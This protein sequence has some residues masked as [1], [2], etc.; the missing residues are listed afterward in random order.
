MQLKYTLSFLLKLCIKKWWQQQQKKHMVLHVTNIF[1]SLDCFCQGNSFEKPCR[2]ARA[3]Q[4]SLPP[5][6]PLR[7]GSLFFPFSAWRLGEVVLE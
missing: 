7:L 4:Y 2:N 1:S 5:E 6:L 3:D